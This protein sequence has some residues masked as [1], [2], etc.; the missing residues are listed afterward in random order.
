MAGGISKVFL[1]RVLYSSTFTKSQ[2]RFLLCQPH[3]S[4]HV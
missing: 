4:D 3:G 1:Q 2:G